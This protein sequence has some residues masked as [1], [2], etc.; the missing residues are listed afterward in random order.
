MT[1]AAV[2]SSTIGN[3]AQFWEK[4]KERVVDRFRIGQHQRALSEIVDGQRRQHD[5]EP[6]KPDRAASEV[7]KIGI[8]RF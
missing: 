2:A 5:Y 4:Q 6:G 7:T 3:R 8:K 1:V